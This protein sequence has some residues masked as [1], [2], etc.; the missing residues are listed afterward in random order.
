VS[1]TTPPDA[2]TS[3]TA[4]TPP[5][6]D[7]GW[8][9]AVVAT[10]LPWCVGRVAVLCSLI[11]A[12]VA[13]DQL[14]VEHPPPLTDRLLAW[15][16]HQY[17]AIAED[18]YQ[19][20]PHGFRF[21]PGMPLLSRGFGWLLGGH[22][23][24]A[25][26]VLANVAAFA[27]GLA[28]YRLV[29]HECGR[30]HVAR[31]STWLLLAT[32][33]T[34]PLTMGY[35]ESIGL[36]GVVLTFLAVRTGRWRI[37]T[38]PAAAVG[39]TW[40]IGALLALPLAVEAVRTWRTASIVGRVWR[41]VAGLAPIAATAA[42]LMWVQR[43][44]GSWRRD[45]F[46]VQDRIYHRGFE[47]PIGRIIESAGDLV[48]GH[49]AQGIQFLWVL[50]AIPLIVVTFRRLPLSYGIWSLAIFLVAISAHNIDSFER[51]LLRAFPIAIAGAL[52]LRNDKSEWAVVS[53]GLAGLV[54]YGTAIFL[55]ARVP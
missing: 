47:E 50:L 9:D 49:H 30:A 4:T 3:A 11:L 45:V 36:L 20:I 18:G 52:S 42:Y 37:A 31:L 29:L 15:D 44:T 46:E 5:L 10:A 43:E 53:I 17:R 19:A 21:F 34:A 55:G 54:V 39:L 40:S 51:Y 2:P 23:D 13:T 48:A 27:L 22:V 8:R 33:A 26:I 12:T 35:A 41:A 16:A 38:I 1:G 24:V 25:M 32:P 14:G 6:N 7:S 28:L